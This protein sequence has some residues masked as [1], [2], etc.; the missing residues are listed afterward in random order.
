VAFALDTN[1][2]CIDTTSSTLV[3]CSCGEQ[4]YGTNNSEA[5]LKTKDGRRWL[6]ARGNE[7]ALG[8]ESAAQPPATV[9]P[10]VWDQC[11]EQEWDNLRGSSNCDFVGCGQH[12]ESHC[13]ANGSNAGI[14]T[15]S[16]E[17]QVQ[18]FPAYD[19]KGCLKASCETDDDCATGERCVQGV[20]WVPQCSF[21]SRG[22][23]DCGASW[24]AGF[25]P[26]VCVDV[27][28]A[29][30]RGPWQRYRAED[31]QRGVIWE[32][33]PDGTLF[34]TT[35]GVLKQTKVDAI[36]LA[37]LNREL[38]SYG[39]RAGAQNGF[40]CPVGGSGIPGS[41]A[42]DVAGKT[43]ARDVSGCFQD[44]PLAITLS[45]YG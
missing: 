31:G 38:N 41:V 1:R 44:L 2:G 33:L 45:K 20:G 23:C 34:I 35:N 43:Y 29:G 28:S 17:N 6:V 4:K 42:L 8:P 30:P 21:D 32:L 19:A 13:S 7:L 25:D 37:Y 22:G 40:I 18:N 24:S 39:I 9:D 27:A 3:T 16:C 26:A 14:W 11:A 15:M 36:D 5:C 10:A 12:I